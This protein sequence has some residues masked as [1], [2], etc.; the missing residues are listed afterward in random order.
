[1]APPLE[2]VAKGVT[3][4]VGCGSALLRNPVLKQEIE[5]AFQSLPFV[6]SDQGDASLG[7]ALAMCRDK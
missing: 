3:Q 6:Y 1:M 2:M 5:R 7:A 4:G